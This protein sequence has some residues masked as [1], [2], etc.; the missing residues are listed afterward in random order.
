MSSGLNDLGTRLAEVRDHLLDAARQVARPSWIWIA[1]VLYPAFDLGLDVL[2]VNKSG[3]DST[4]STISLPGISLDGVPDLFAGDENSLKVIG[5]ILVLVI[6]ALLLALGIALVASRLSAGLASC[7]T[8]NTWDEL[9]GAA[10]PPGLRAAWAAGEGLTSS[11]FGI[12]VLLTLMR[13]M[14]ILIVGLPL[15]LFHGVLAEGPSTAS[16]VL[17]GI[18]YL[19]LAG[20]LILYFV[21]LAALHQLAL[22]S[23][24]QNRRGMTSAIQHAWRLFR[25]EASLSLAYLL[26]EV[27]T[28]LIFAVAAFVISLCSIVICCLVPL[29]P[30]C[31]L[32]LTGLQGVLRAAFW[33]RA[34]GDMGGATSG[35]T[36]GGIPASPTQS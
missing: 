29:L 25:V 10:H 7:A 32:A 21:V 23:L 1:G 30:L 31:L 2:H 17:L 12:F 27:V 20:L 15:V 13:I 18:I 5:G 26:I 14:A 8:P 22:H 35:D 16:G 19:P 11:A 36:L 28:I 4:T 34:Y 6:L 24:V 3:G 33:A 9:G